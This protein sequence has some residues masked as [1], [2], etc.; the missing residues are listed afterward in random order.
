M[1]LSKATKQQLYEIATND[2]NRMSDRYA[3]AREM[4]RR[5]KEDA[6]CRNRS[7]N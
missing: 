1:D 2:N 4:Q 6:L 7:I 3:A 5:R